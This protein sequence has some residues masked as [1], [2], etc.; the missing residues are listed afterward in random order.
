MSPKTIIGGKL[1]FYFINL[2]YVEYISDSKYN[3]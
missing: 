2:K 3:Y 1:N